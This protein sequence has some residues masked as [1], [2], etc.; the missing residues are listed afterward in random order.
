MHAYHSVFLV[1]G[2]EAS[3]IVDTGPPKDWTVIEAQLNSLLSK[4]NVPPVRYLFP[5]HSEV[6]HAANLGRLLD[7]FPSAVVWGDVR[8]L[9]LHM[10]EHANRMLQA[11]IGDTIDLGS[12][13]FRAVSPVVRDL[14]T[15]LWGYDEESRV[16]FP[17]DGFAYMHHHE[18]GECG[19][20]AEELPD[21]P[22][23]EF[24][25]IFSHYALYWTR[26]TAMQQF[27]DRLRG[28]LREHPV[29]VIAPGHGSPITQPAVTMPRVEE[30][31]LG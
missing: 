15:T 18:A 24:M 21:L 25:R 30:G 8:D 3:V 22:L 29:D 2:S 16:L 28:L 20:T 27:V 26:Y 13:T 19:K 1:H 23:P 10:P 7:R 17:A 5:T 31:L 4:G 12:K 11:S 14:V 9:H 6:P